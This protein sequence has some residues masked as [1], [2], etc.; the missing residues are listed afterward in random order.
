MNAHETP[1]IRADMI[2]LDAGIDWCRKNPELHDQREYAAIKSCGTTLCL[3]GAVLQLNGW[4]PV[5]DWPRLAT[6]YFESPEGDFRAAHA[7]ARDLLGLSYEQAECLFTES[8]NLADLVE[9][10]DRI[11][12]G[13]LQ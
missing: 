6:A 4:R 5:F 3:A 8:F 10:R 1:V 11:A 2:R 9:V 13:S 12:S 7:A